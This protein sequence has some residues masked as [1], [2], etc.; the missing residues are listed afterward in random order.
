MRQR[1][2]RRLLVDTLNSANG[3]TVFAPTNDAFSAL[4]KATLN[5]AMADPKACSPPCSPTTWSRAS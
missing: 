3:I 4:P 5:A 1:H 2:S